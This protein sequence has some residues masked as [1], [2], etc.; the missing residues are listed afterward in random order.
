MK[1][2][3]A[4]VGSI[5]MLSARAE[6]LPNLF[7]QARDLTHVFEIS[8]VPEDY[9]GNIDSR[10][11]ALA[12]LREALARER[13]VQA[14]EKLKRTIRAIE[15]RMAEL[16]AF[17]ARHRSLDLSNARIFRVRTFDGRVG[18]SHYYSVIR[19]DREVARYWI[20]NPDDADKYVPAIESR[21]TAINVH[22]GVSEFEGK[23]I[24]ELRI[25]DLGIVCGS[26]QL[27]DSGEYWRVI[28]HSGIA[29]LPQE[30]MLI[31][32]L[33]GYTSYTVPRQHRLS[34]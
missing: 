9:W 31:R 23:E 27:T 14:I 15:S 34:R 19:G 12:W 29:G 20:F 21:Y 25:Y 5:L 1:A 28:V 13:D 32:K 2:T 30:E 8:A 18:A 16:K 17:K 11:A 7:R 22:D 6:E 3:L 10:S 33:D 26:P 4:I 24:A